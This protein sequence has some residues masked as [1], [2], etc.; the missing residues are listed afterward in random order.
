MRMRAR[1]YGLCHTA[2][3]NYADGWEFGRMNKNVEP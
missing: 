1:R 2:A 3:A